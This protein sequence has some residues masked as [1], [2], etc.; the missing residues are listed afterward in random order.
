[1]VYHSDTI[2]MKKTETSVPSKVGFEDEKK[3]KNLQTGLEQKQEQ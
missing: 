3:T 2:E 1:V